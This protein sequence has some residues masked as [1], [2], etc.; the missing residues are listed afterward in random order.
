MKSQESFEEVLMQELRLGGIDDKRLSDL[1]KT[2]AGIKKSGMDRIRVFPKGIP[3]P[4]GIRVSGIVDAKVL[5][6]LLEDTLLKT[7]RLGGVSAFP[8]GIPWPDV[9]RVNIDIG[10]FSE[11]EISSETF[12]HS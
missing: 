7:P 4:E 1:V 2:I 3:H 11:I 12:K 5:S 8:F 6:K 9:F 10:S